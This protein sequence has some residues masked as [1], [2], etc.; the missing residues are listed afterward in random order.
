MSYDGKERR[1]EME[2]TLMIVSSLRGFAPLSQPPAKSKPINLSVLSPE[3]RSMP[4]PDP[5][6]MDAP[7]GANWRGTH[8]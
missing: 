5:A 7:R 4:V 3:L 1:R 6:Y 2:R 8:D